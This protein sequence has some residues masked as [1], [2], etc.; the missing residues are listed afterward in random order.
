LLKSYAIDDKELII[1]SLESPIWVPTHPE[2]SQMAAF[3]RFVEKKEGVFLADY[4]ALH[5]FSIENIPAFWM[6]LCDFFKL[7]WNTPTLAVLSYADEQQESFPE[8]AP[9]LMKARWFKGATFNMAEKWLSRHDEHPALI[10][11]H[12]DG[13]RQVVSY[14]LLHELTAQCAAGLKVL[15]VGVGDRVVGILPNGIYAVV[16]LLATASLGAIWSSC[17]PDFGLEAIVDRFC[18][19]EPKVLFMT[20][21]QCYQ[22]KT[23][24][25]IA[26]IEPLMA[27]I[28]SLLQVVVC[29]DNDKDCPL[30]LPPQV[31]MWGDFLVPMVPLVFSP[32]PFSHPL[33]IL[34][35]SG[36]TGKPKCIVHTAGGTLL[37]HIKELGLHVD[38]TADDILFFY[39]TTGWM[40]WNWM[41]S[42]LLLGATLVLYDG[43]P[44]FPGPQRLFQV[45]ESE[46]VSIFGTS[47]SFIAAVE[48]TAFIPRNDFKMQA[49]RTILSTGSPLLPHHYDF[50]ETSVKP[51]VQISSMSG[52]TDIVS[53][54]ALSNPLL[55]VYRGQLQSLGLGMAV[56]VYD[57]TGHSVIDKMGELVCEKPFPSMPKGFWNDVSN[58]RYYR[59]YFSQFIGVWTH[60]D[61]AMLTPMHGLIIYGR[62]DAVLNPGGVRIGTAEIYRQVEKIPEVLESVV[63]GQ[64]WQDNIRIVLFIKLKN[65]LELDCALKERIISLIRK[66]ASPRHVPAVILAVPDIPK[67]MNGKTLELVVRDLV[68]GRAICNMHAI[69]NPDSLAYF[70]DLVALQS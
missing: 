39:T 12:E 57:D 22:G 36:T 7:K 37:Q 23:H 61:L 49:L 17:S 8:H 53:C 44:L 40:M 5:R 70:K 38:L 14:A 20:D 69:A 50:V 43:A 66:N 28:P 19:I 18:Q 59:A 15:G 46:N 29:F 25:Y 27:Q 30:T 65:N 54:F 33:M 47:A 56:A 26:R 60:G 32:Q 34:F 16:A 4:E 2:R 3:M 48:K 55:P 10:Y 9:L 24:H 51:S 42:G 41:V 1:M 64:N 68:H 6:A 13:R 45:I 35:S 67:T 21:K 62:S 11:L 58:E 63:I 31:L 52:G